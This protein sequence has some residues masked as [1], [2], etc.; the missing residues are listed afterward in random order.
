M[1]KLEHISAMYNLELNK[2]IK[3]VFEQFL[4][5]QN[6]YQRIAIIC[7]KHSYPKKLMAPILNKLSVTEIRY[8][9][10]FTP[11]PDFDEILLSLITFTKF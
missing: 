1:M 5:K 6:S 8:F 9:N 2:S 4:E 10:E 11:N 7:G 3:P